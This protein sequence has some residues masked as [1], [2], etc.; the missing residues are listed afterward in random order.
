M[1]AATIAAAQ[2]AKTHGQK[3]STDPLSDTTRREFLRIIADLPA[4]S[5]FTANT[6]RQQ[7]DDAGIPDR[8]RAGMFA[9]AC[10]AGL[11]RPE[12]V[13][14]DGVGEVPVSVPSTG[15]FAHRAMV[16]VYR[17]TELA[18]RV[19]PTMCGECGDPLAPGDRGYHPVCF[20]LTDGDQG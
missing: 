13:D 2:A 11:C 9:G 14:V 5:R 17:R 1:S 4:G 18:L 15:A 10:T 8:S 16:R 19:A 12:M 6:I 3:Q 20:M 7:L